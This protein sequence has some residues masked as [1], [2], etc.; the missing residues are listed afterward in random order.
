[1]KNKYNISIRVTSYIPLYILKKFTVQHLSILSYVYP[2]QQITEI[3]KKTY[4]R[5]FETLIY[6][7][8]VHTFFT[9]DVPHIIT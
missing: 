9:Q 2:W 8:G 5:T 4:N 1:M 6:V 3:D 7:R